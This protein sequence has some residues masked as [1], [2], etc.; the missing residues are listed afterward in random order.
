MAFGGE[1]FGVVVAADVASAD[2]AL[3]A[4]GALLVAAGE[5]SGAGGGAFWAVVVEACEGDA[6]GGEGVEVGCADVGGAGVGEVAVAEVV[7]EDEDDV[8]AFGGLGR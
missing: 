8:G 2:G 4:A 3:E 5:E 6:A 7:G 1:G